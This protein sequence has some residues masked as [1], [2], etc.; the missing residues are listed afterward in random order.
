MGLPIKIRKGK[1]K[2]AKSQAEALTVD[3]ERPPQRPHF[4]SRKP[5][6]RDMTKPAQ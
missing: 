2:K 4:L 6:R 5:F 3:G 1:A